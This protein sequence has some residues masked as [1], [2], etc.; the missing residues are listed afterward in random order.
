MW[1]NTELF[2]TE[3]K[4]FVKYGRYCD[5]PPGSMGF[6]DYWN[7]QTN[8][9]MNGYS[10]GGKEITGDHYFYL[11]FDQ[12]K[13]TTDDDDAGVTKKRVRFKSKIVTF[14]DFWDGDYDYYWHL[15]I[16]EKGIE[17]DKL[18]QIHIAQ[19]PLWTDGGHHVMCGKARR[20]GFSYKN[21]A[22]AANRYNTLKNSITLIGAFDKK[23]LYPNGTMS[24]V[25]DS[26]NFLNEHT[27]WTK[28]RAVTDRMEHVKASY[29]E[30]L[31]GQYVEKGY[32][33]QIIAVTF[34]DN[35]DAARGKDASLIL[36]EECGAFNNLRS[37]YLATQ[38]TVEDGAMI[39]GQIILYGT[40]GDME[41]GT[42]DFESMFYNPEPYNIYPIENVWDEGAQNTFCG[43]FFPDFQ[44]KKGF[45]DKE[46]NSN[47][48][49]AKIY[50]EAKRDEIRRTAKSPAILDKYV[51]ERPFNPREAFLRTSGNIF[52][53][54]A[55]SEWRNHVYT[56]SLYKNLAVHGFMAYNAEG[57]TIFKPSDAARPVA[58]FPHDKGDNLHGCVVTYQSPFT[59]ADGTVPD[60]LYM[61]CC[62][63]YAQDEGGGKSLGAA[64]VIKRI[65]SLSSPDDMIVASWVGRPG[66]QDD[67][68]DTLFMLSDYYNARIGFEND[69]GNIIEYAKRKHLLKRLLEEVEIIDK[70]EK[71]N[72]RKLGRSYGMSISNKER[73]GQGEIYFRDWLT[74]KRA[75]GEDGKEKL[76]L[77]YIYDLALLDELIRY[78]SGNFDR[79]SAM[80]VGMYHMKDLHNRDVTEVME[81]Q[82]DSFWNRDFF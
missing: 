14:P 29:K 15:A 57:K 64:F 47:T 28:R 6:M 72:I 65:N 32:K 51:T 41:G 44:N 62:D 74:M 37:S 46:G 19:K 33:S 53:T 69:R 59:G 68:N 71:I 34:A 26:L 48:E 67:Y 38:S 70:R 31:N 56:H 16:A 9:C 81:E 66:T 11:N 58:K 43:F 5:D 80:I 39:T 40:G 25:V 4:N 82:P 45:I 3:A 76:N 78:G 63:P 36:L 60:N 30:M 17:Q 20:K 75:K 79:V 54:V 73:K 27:A 21:A 55:I 23:Y 8:R 52:P 42:I 7:E 49:D 50:E 10:V 77:H 12:I 22:K 18:A 1:I 13:L 35:P 2:R 24:M 61:I